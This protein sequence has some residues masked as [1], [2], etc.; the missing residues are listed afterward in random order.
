MNELEFKADSNNTVKQI[1]P[2]EEIALKISQNIDQPPA[3][4]IPKTFS[5][6][7]IKSYNTCPYQYKLSYIIKLPI[8]QTHYFSFGNTIHNTLHEFYKLVQILNSARQESLFD[9]PAQPV[10]KNTGAIKVPDLD[11]LFKIYE[12]QWQG[13][14]FL[15]AKQREKYHEDGKKMLSV[16]Y[17]KQ[18]NHWTVPLA[19]ESGFNIKIEDFSIKG[20]IDRIDRQTD[21]RLNII[22]YKTGAGKEKAQGD[23]K[24]QLLLY[25]IAVSSLPQYSAWGE[26]GQLSLY[27]IKDDMIANFLGQ[28]K[29]MARQK[30]K[31]S[32]TANKIKKGIFKAT[33]E[34]NA[35][36]YCHFR[37]ICEFKI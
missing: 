12:N 23:E 2:Q 35:C 18:A 37:D 20:R 33:P 27:Y 32:Q 19:L 1:L 5:F 34:K 24:D 11:E 9:Q 10:K 21:G 13:N 16:F 25:Q 3:Y 26:I 6:S 31:I 22:D 30:E 17:K 15:S 29:D 36:K 7:Q 28:E 14:W 4:L 8:A